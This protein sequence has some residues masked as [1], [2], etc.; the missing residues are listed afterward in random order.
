VTEDQDNAAA[1]ARLEEAVAHLADQIRQGKA[2]YLQGQKFLRVAAEAERRRL[3]KGGAP[4]P[5][6]PA[7]RAEIEAGLDATAARIAEAEAGLAK[8][9]A[10]LEQPAAPPQP[11]PLTVAEAGQ[12]LLDIGAGEQALASFAADPEGMTE[13]INAVRCSPL[14]L[15][16]KQALIDGESVESV[17]ARL[18]L[19]V[20]GEGE[21]PH[22]GNP[23]A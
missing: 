5:A 11:Q 18:G 7:Q 8:L 23:D 10:I 20:P 1:R 12:L 4:D 22:D 6:Y 9:T 17:A 15:A 16:V 14:D 2:G 3:R 19:A 21:Q 13:G